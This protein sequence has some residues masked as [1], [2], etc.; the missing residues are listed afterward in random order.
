MH[1]DDVLP[2]PKCAVGRTFLKLWVY[3]SFQSSHNCIHL[4]IYSSSREDTPVE[5]CYGTLDNSMRS[6]TAGHAPAA[7]SPKFRIPFVA[8]A[9]RHHTVALCS[10]TSEGTKPNPKPAPASK[11][12]IQTP[13]SPPTSTA[14]L[15]KDDSNDDGD[16]EDDDD[17]EGEGEEEEEEED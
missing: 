11:W 15:V 12:V 4:R 1:V 13:E 10:L 9:L 3:V 14:E 17:E 6:S 8:I 7:Q 5:I 2:P 16:D